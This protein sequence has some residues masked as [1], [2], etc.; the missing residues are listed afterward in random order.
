[1][2]DTGRDQAVPAATTAERKLSSLTVTFG[3]RLALLR[4]RSGLT[5]TQLAAKLDTH[6]S[7][8]RRWEHDQ[9]LPQ[10]YRVVA[11][12]RILHCSRKDLFG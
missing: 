3:A 6:A 12:C 11:L 2:A 1:M 7:V 9:N 8:I 5:Q 4:R 10:P